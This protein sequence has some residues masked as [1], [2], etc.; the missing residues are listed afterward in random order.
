MKRSG[1]QLLGLALGVWAALGHPASAHAQ[2]LKWVE[3]AASKGDDVVLGVDRN[4]LLLLSHPGKAPMD[5]SGTASRMAR[6]EASPWQVSMPEVWGHVPQ[7]EE[8]W[9]QT[10]RILHL[11][12]DPVHGM[13]VLSTL[14]EGKGCLW[15]SSQTGAGPHR[16][17]PPWSIPALET[18]MGDCAFAAFDVHPDREGD[19]LVALRPRMQGGPEEL[20]PAAGEWKGGYDV[21]RIPRLGGYQQVWI[22]D[23]I[24]S[25]ADEMALVPGPD[26]G[27][28]LSTERLLGAGGLDPWWCPII[29]LGSPGQEADAMRLEGHTLEA[30]C[31]SRALEGLVWQVFSSSGAP[32][33]RM[34]TDEQGRINLG[35]LSMETRY[36]FELVGVPPEGCRN[37]VVLWRDGTGR[38]LRRFVIE[39]GAWSLSLLAVLPLD[40][41]RELRPDASIL[42]AMGMPSTA[43]AAEQVGMD[44]V[45]FHSIGQKSL[46]ARD[47][48][49]LRALAL[50]LRSR[51]EDV[52]YIVG[53]AS[54]DGNP[55]ANATLASE[56]ARHVA[57]QL[58]F[59][60]LSSTQIRFEGRG[61][62]L[63]M[64]HCP[65]G[66]A[67]PEGQLERSRRT[68]LHIRIGGRSHGG[69]M[70]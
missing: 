47:R 23:D 61:D 12:I 33:E 13:A 63:P 19:L 24:N 70:Q 40:G 36:D 67:C 28:W 37:A 52:V 56:R 38:I 68:E 35:S 11:D 2:D 53:H 6:L 46:S 1:Y 27:G 65:P 21:V 59:A 20:E 25:A 39:D 7:V 16:W 49:H 58:E 42:P 64:E 44:W 43:V 5:W 34:S 32:L 3:K 51:P 17:N 15:L 50:Q 66:V 31:G 57:A 54:R 55:T 41:W 62:L 60:G 14:K 69:P 10:G 48:D 26:G 4:H 45:I 8:G 29:P 30:R 9:D 18:F 22:L